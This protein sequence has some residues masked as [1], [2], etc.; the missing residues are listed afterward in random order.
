MVF[1]FILI[2]LYTPVLLNCIVFLRRFIYCIYYVGFFPGSQTWQGC[3]FGLHIVFIF[4]VKNSFFF[5]NVI[6]VIL[7]ETHLIIFTLFF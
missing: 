7:F 4:F 5:C 3:L 2:T 6:P 1:V